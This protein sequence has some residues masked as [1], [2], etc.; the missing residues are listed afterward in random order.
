MEFICKT[1]AGRKTTNQKGMMIVL[2]GEGRGEQDEFGKMG[3]D[4][5]KRN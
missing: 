5:K 4:G 1:Q 2:D 3:G